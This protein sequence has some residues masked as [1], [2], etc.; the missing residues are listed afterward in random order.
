[1]KTKA[2]YLKV[3]FEIGEKNKMECKLPV[4]KTNTSQLLTLEELSYKTIDRKEIVIKLKKNRFIIGPEEMDE[5]KFRLS[6]LSSKCD[7]L[8]DISFVKAKVNI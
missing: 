4:A 5:K 7:V 8:K 3:S 2:D 6:E 1:V